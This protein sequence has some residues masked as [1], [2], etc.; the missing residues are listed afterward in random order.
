MHWTTKRER[1]P[2]VTIATARLARWYLVDFCNKGVDVS[3]D[4]IFWCC[5][6]SQEP[7][8]TLL[9]EAYASILWIMKQFCGI[10]LNM[11]SFSTELN[12]IVSCVSGHGIHLVSGESWVPIDKGR[13]GVRVV[14]KYW[15][16]SF[17]VRVYD[18]MSLCWSR[19]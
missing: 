2:D 18:L 7:G 4:D 13:C 8:E 10:V 1:W 16:S 14:M 5:S 19:R 9:L 12:R 3:L 6:Q 17:V 15:H 11:I